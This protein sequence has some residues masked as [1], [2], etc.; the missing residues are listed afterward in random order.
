MSR[1][2]CVGLQPVG[3]HSDGGG[4]TVGDGRARD[5]GILVDGVGED[6]AHDGIW[7][8]SIE[9]QVIEG[10]T[11]DF[12]MV[13]GRERPT[14]TAKVREFNGQFYWDENGAPKTLERGRFDWFG[15]DPNWKEQLGYLA[16]K[17]IEKPVVARNRQERVSDR[18]TSTESG[19][20]VV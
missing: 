6:G 19:N 15:L 12:I 7:L 13:N 3:R 18:F 10:G 16:P 4:V 8:Q 9:S 20:G 11:G 1:L 2:G 17:E 5:S 14:M